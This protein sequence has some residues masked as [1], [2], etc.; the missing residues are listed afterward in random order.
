MPHTA[1]QIA[2]IGFLSW[3]WYIILSGLY[4]LK[5]SYFRCDFGVLFYMKIP[6]AP[7]QAVIIN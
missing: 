4:P 7:K 2:F 3:Q 1:A 6:P 5:N